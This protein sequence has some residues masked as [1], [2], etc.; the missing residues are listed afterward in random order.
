[1]LLIMDTL[2]NSYDF[3]LRYEIFSCFFYF[4]NIV[5]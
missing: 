4:V 1:M 5:R 2:I 3:I